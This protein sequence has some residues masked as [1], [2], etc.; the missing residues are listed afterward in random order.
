MEKKEFK[1]KLSLNKQTIDKLNNDL[2][3]G[4]KGGYEITNISLCGNCEITI[5]PGCPG[6][7]ETGCLLN[8]TCDGK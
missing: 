1:K 3:N 4:I 8:L 6:T 2:L 7:I 5:Y